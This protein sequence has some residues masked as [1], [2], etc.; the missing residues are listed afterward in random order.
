MKGLGWVNGVHGALKPNGDFEMAGNIYGELQ[1]R[2]FL[3]DCAVMEKNAIQLKNAIIWDENTQSF[4]SA[5]IIKLSK[6]EF[7]ATNHYEMQSLRGKGQPPLSLSSENAMGSENGPSHLF[8]NVL[9]K[10]EGLTVNAPQAYVY[11]WGAVF[12]DADFTGP[13]VRKGHAD[14]LIVVEKQHVIWMLGNADV[15]DKGGNRITGHK[16]T[17]STIT[18]RISVYSGKKKVRIKLAL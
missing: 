3:S 13:Q 16:L 2:Q 18:G 6:K 1:N 14:L 12:F 9:T 11:K 15:T 8:G 17:L 5:G 7:S 4:S 10:M